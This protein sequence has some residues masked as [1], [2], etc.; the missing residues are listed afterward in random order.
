LLDPYGSRSDN[1]KQ[2]K[3]MTISEIED[4][5]TTGE[6]TAAQCFT[7]MRQHCQDSKRVGSDFYNGIEWMAAWM[8]DNVEGEEVD[9]LTLRQWA[10]D[11]WLLHLENTEMMGASRKD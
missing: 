7:Q 1:T 9:E 6:M 4:R 10:I 3:L 11:A 5:V 8:V 2:I